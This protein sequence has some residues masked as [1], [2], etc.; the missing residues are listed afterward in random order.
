MPNFATPQDAEDAFYDALDEG[1]LEAM[2]NV[3]ERSS[4]IACLLPMQP[5]ARG[6]GDVSRV[7]G[8]VLADGRKL[9]ISVKHL[10]WTEMADV[11]MHLVE[12]Q[13]PPPPGKPAF[14]VYGINVYRRGEDGW[15]MLM[16][17]NAPTPPPAASMPPMGK[18]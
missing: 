1:D 18:G 14:P 4:E 10:A 11:A 9:E 12:E 7:W 3:W 8:A 6:L 5:L 13:V 17:H 2:M 16:H 15:K